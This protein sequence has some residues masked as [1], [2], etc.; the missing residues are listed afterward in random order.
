MGVTLTEQIIVEVDLSI[1]PY[2]G[3]IG[4][5]QTQWT[6][7]LEPGFIYYF[8]RD[9]PISYNILPGDIILC[10]KE[11]IYVCD[12]GKVIMPIKKFKPL[13]LIRY[14]KENP[15]VEILSWDYPGRSRHFLEIARDF[16]RN[17]E[18]LSKTDVFE[19]DDLIKLITSLIQIS[20]FNTENLL[21]PHLKQQIYNSIIDTLDILFSEACLEKICSL[22]DD[23]SAYEILALV[24]PKL[25]FSFPEYV[26]SATAYKKIKTAIGKKITIKEKLTLI[27]NL[28]VKDIENW[29]KTNSSDLVNF[30]LLMESNY[31]DLAKKVL[32]IR[33]EEVRNA[34]VIFKGATKKQ[35]DI[36]QLRETTLGKKLI[37]NLKIPERKKWIE[38]E[39]F[40][41]IELAFKKIGIELNVIKYVRPE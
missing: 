37:N 17:K 22:K 6:S 39:V 36:S 1:H 3:I 14:I 5:F 24:L 29:L 2:Q 9:S 33:Q 19:K 30:D 35:Y 21:F 13:D 11:P 12:S 31:K 26:T 8:P 28:F 34:P 18:K 23:L 40:A 16:F 7:W 10:E 27:E 32:Q 4:S 38:Q 20:Q 15:D 41:L 25:F